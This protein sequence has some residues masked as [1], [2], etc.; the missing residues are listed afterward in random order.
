MEIAGL[1]EMGVTVAEIAQ[2][3]GSPVTTIRHWARSGRIASVLE[4]HRSE[5]RPASLGESDRL[6]YDLTRNNISV[7]EK[8]GDTNTRY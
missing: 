1:L 8:V 4:A 6:R 5:P 7:R 2:A 3:T